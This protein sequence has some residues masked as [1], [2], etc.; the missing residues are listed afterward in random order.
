MDSQKIISKFLYVKLVATDISI[1][2]RSGYN[3][4]MATGIICVSCT[5]GLTH[6]LTY[7]LKERLGK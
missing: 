5:S 6:N 4:E 1:D 7:H 3:E 2:I